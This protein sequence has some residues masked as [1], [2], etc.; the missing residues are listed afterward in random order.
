MQTA[1]DEVSF[2]GMMRRLIGEVV[3][4][5]PYFARCRI[6]PETVF[7]RLDEDVDETDLRAI[8][9]RAATLLRLGDAVA[10]P[11]RGGRVGDWIE[12]LGRCLREH[13]TSE[14][15]AC[16]RLAAGL[17][18]AAGRGDPDRAVGPDLAGAPTPRQPSPGE[19]HHDLEGRHDHEPDHV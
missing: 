12:H 4:L 7:G 1:P 14:D 10:L 18:L 17:G 6:G 13:G 8:R 19:H 15:E 16:A 3:G 9:A 11:G 5:D 2:Y